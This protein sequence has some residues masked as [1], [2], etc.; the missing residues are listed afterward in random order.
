M[1]TMYGTYNFVKP[2][3][4]QKEKWSSTRNDHFYNWCNYCLFVVLLKRVDH[5]ILCLLHAI[6]LGY[7][8]GLPWNDTKTIFHGKTHFY[9]P[10]NY[11]QNKSTKS[12]QFLYQKTLLSGSE[13]KSVSKNSVCRMWSLQSAVLSSSNESWAFHGLWLSRPLTLL[14]ADSLIPGKKNE[15]V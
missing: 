12:K 3:E 1:G 10:L 7:S 8:S 15:N 9:T 14:T 2:F 4:I 5:Q 13:Q 6:P 11:T